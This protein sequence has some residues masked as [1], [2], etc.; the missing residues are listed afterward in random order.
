MEL[1]D[2]FEQ[3]GPLE[4]RLKGHRVGIDTILFDYRDGLTPEEIAVRYPTLTMEQI[5]ATITY[6]WRYRD[7]VDA[8]LHAVEEDEEQFWREVEANPQP[9]VIRLRELMKARHANTVSV[10]A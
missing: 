5:Y 7:Q 4:I 9:E 8:F 2:Y 6:Y 10:M 1:E 3:I